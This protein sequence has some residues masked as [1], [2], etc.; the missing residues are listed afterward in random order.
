MPNQP[1][2]SRPLAQESTLRAPRS[3]VRSPRPS[4]DG[5]LDGSRREPQPD[6]Q[7]IGWRDVGVQPTIL[8]PAAPDQWRRR[9]AP[10]SPASSAGGRLLRSR[11]A[12]GPRLRSR[13]C[14]S[15]GRVAGWPHSSSVPVR[16][17]RRLHTA[18]PRA[19]AQRWRRGSDASRCCTR[20]RVHRRQL[21]GGAGARA[22]D[23]LLALAKAQ[24]PPVG[25]ATAVVGQRLVP[26]V[27]R[28]GECGRTRRGKRHKPLEWITVRKAKAEP[29]C[30]AERR[31]RSAGRGGPR[32]RPAR[33]GWGRR[34]R[35]ARRVPGSLSCAGTGGCGV[36]LPRGNGQRAG[37]HPWERPPEV[38][39][40][41]SALRGWAAGRSGQKATGNASPR[42]GVGACERVRR[43]DASS[44]HPPS[45][46]PA[47]GAAASTCCSQAGGFA[48][49]AISRLRLDRTVCRYSAVQADKT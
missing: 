2:C 46:C 32:L 49:L 3:S 22:G 1:T 17:R 42:R 26:C 34:L 15:T 4:R 44:L 48:I 20:R 16:S 35:A 14:R 6:R 9:R 29:V 38:S 24:R 40:S 39:S 7:Q 33:T 47:E 31:F 41:N 45:L 12:C 23:E 25:P 13:R 36:E 37:I 19:V 18:V 21:P 28:D 30:G 27:P 8:A 10:T 43:P 5:R 11:A